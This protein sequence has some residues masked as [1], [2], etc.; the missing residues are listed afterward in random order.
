MTE[1]KKPWRTAVSTY[2]EGSIAIGGYRVKDLMRN[3]DFG[4]ALFVLYQQR[5]PSAG[6]AK[7]LN[8]MMISVLDHGIVA[9]SAIARIIAASG[10]PLQA[11]AAAGILSIGD[12]H[13]GAGEQVA[14]R[15]T[16]QVAAA[17]VAGKSIADHATDIVTAAR[18]KKERIEGYGHPLHPEVDERVDTMVEMARE[19]GLVGP[20]LELALAIGDEIHRQS[21]RKIPLNVDGAMAGIL[22]DL[23]FDWRLTR[24]FVFVPRAAGISA[25]AVEEVVRERGWRVIAKHGDVDYDGPPVREYPVGG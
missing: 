25:H 10:V 6:E 13:G 16:E 11:C 22:M 2:D 4:G 12:V 5:V 20:H 14:K 23:G 21:G 19:L 9:P 18:A 8:A 3:L 17:K 24:L 1:T 15:L 7:L